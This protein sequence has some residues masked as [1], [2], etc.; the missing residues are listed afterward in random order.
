MAV[1]AFCVSANDWVNIRSKIDNY[2]EHEDFKMLLKAL[3]LFGARQCEMLAKSET[4]RGN[5]GPKGDDVWKKTISLKNKQIETIVFRIRTARM[6]KPRT[7]LLPSNFEPWA[8]ELYDYFEK[9]GKNYVFTF[10]RV[11]TWKR[12]KES[13]LFEG[14]K[15]INPPRAK[16]N[17]DFNLDNLRFIR[18]TELAEKYGFTKEEL[19]AYG[20]R[21][22]KKGFNDL[23]TEKFQE[24][25][26][27]KL[28][29]PKERE[30]ESALSGSNEGSIL[31]L[32]SS[33]SFLGLD[34]NWSSAACALILQ[35]VAIMLVAEKLK[36]DLDETNVERILGSKI[37]SKDFSFNHQYEAFGSEVKRMFDV[38]MPFL[39]TQFRRIRAKIVHDGY[40]PEPEERE[41][42]VNFTTGLLQK[43]KSV[44]AT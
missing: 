13:K 10:G 36:I 40:N 43:L 8:K 19:Q 11:T 34:M 15:K 12:T 37:E 27:W 33:A 3:Y 30:V 25:Y 14:L 5:V 21:T 35:E 1:G 44:G 7:V 9:N 17:L 18:M 29:N 38:D 41:S 42:I 16:K 23:E 20:F 24:E 28:C 32:M 6:G 39:T 2:T 22:L 4:D 31:S 26:L